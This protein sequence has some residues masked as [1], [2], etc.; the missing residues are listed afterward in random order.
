MFQLDFEYFSVYDAGKIGIDL[1]VSLQ[2][3][4]QTVDFTAKIDT[5]SSRCIFERRLGEELGL[6]IETGLPQQ[7][8]TATGGFLAFGHELTLIVAG[9]EFESMVFFPENEN[10]NRNV[11]G[12]TGWLDRI[13]LGLIDYE[14]KI[15]LSRYF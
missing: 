4:I 10:I 13:I 9:F 6:Q 7:F 11:L 2:L 15:Y 5:G 12:R 8:G 3:G 14:G 1:D